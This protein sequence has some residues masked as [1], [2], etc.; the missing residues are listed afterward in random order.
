MT[1]TN[2][3]GSKL[4]PQSYCRAVITCRTCKGT[5]LERAPKNAAYWNAP[6]ARRRVR[7]TRI[8]L[9]EQT[10]RECADL[11]RKYLADLR[12]GDWRVTKIG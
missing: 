10:E 11:A 1:C 2:C 6:S 9:R 3:K 12:R 7:N 4:E 8:A 5:G